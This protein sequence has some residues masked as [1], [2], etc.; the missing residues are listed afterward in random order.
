MLKERHNSS[1]SSL[2][3][4]PLIAGLEADDDEEIHTES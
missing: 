3:G 4:P 1:F 2:A